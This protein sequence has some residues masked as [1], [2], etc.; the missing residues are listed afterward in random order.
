MSPLDSDALRVCERLASTFGLPPPASH[1]CS[2][3]RVSIG[4]EIEVPWSSFFPDLWKKYR[5]GELRVGDLAPSELDALRAEC[6]EIEKTLL[7]RLQ[8]TVD[9]GIPRGNDRYW[10]F[11]FRP[12][13]DTLLFTRQVG[14]LSQA[15][16]LPRDKRHSLQL[17]IG[18]IAPCRSLYYLAMVLELFHVDPA[19]MRA[20]LEKRQQIIHSGWMRKGRAGIHRKEADELE[21]G[22]QVASELRLLQLPTEQGELAQLMRTAQWGAN[23][24]AD[25]CDGQATTASQAWVAVEQACGEALKRNGLPD[26]NW[27]DVDAHAQVAIW[28]DF[29]ARMPIIRQA[30]ADLLLE[31]EFGEDSPLLA[32]LDGGYSNVATVRHEK[33]FE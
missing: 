21:A 14:L 6:Y 32:Y 28:I 13:H 8:S 11:A 30:L 20:G 4:A 2:P 15:G 18:G 7:P 5:L 29:S 24:I 17:T 10:E 22:A 12:V 27:G 23:A 25:L 3:G 16:L 26:S 31:V 19:R 9:C 1:G 33:N